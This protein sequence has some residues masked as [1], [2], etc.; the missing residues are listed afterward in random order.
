M[1]LQTFIKQPSEDLKKNLAVDTTSAISAI[2]SVTAVSRGLVAGSAPLGAVGSLSA[3]LLF[4]DISGGTDGERYLVT[5]QVTDADGQQLEAEMEVAVIDGTWAMPDGGP[6]YLS[7]SELVDRFGLEEIER[8]VGDE[9]GRIDRTRLVS[10]LADV[11]AIADA[12]IAARYAVPLSPVPQLVKVVIG[13][14][15]RARLYPQGAPDGVAAASSAALTMLAN[16]SK[17]QL[18]LPS[19][20]VLPD[21]TAPSAAPIVSSP[22]KQRYGNGELD[23]Y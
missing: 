14:M 15:T 18:Q 7:I 10:C 4:V 21:T 20:T 9:S 23:C 13:D 12:Y 2:G 19:A 1:T 5:A 11:Q 6:S 3:G 22:G 16:I 8:L 17:G